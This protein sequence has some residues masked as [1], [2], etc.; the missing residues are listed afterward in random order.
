M[1]PAVAPCGGFEMVIE[2]DFP[3]VPVCVR[4]R[5]GGDLAADIV[6]AVRRLFE[7]LRRR[8]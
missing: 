6:A 4:V 2:F 3:S 1:V 7:R 5:I 8:D